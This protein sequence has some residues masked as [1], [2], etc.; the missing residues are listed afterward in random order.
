MKL[1]SCCAIVLYEYTVAHL[2]I[3][4]FRA[5]WDWVIYVQ[6]VSEALHCLIKYIGC[7]D[8][9]MRRLVRPQ[10][11]GRKLRHFSKVNRIISSRVETQQDSFGI[12]RIQC[13]YHCE[14]I[15]SPGRRKSVCIL[16]AIQHVVGTSVFYW[17]PNCFPKAAEPN[18]QS[19][20]LYW[21]YY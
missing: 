6:R 9:L 17:C 15:D 16:I 1:L 21:Y 12:G 13:V 7:I 11:G 2:A 19:A 4:P 20:S 5:H 10:K 3:A 8:A 14:M 18:P